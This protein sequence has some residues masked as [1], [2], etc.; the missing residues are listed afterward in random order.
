M[1]RSS[2]T[3]SSALFLTIVFI[4]AASSTALEITPFRTANRSPL[5][6][7]YGIPSETSSDLLEAGKYEFS[8]T[9]DIASINVKD[10]TA[11]EQMFLDGELY[12]WSLIGRYG[13]GQNLELGFEL[14]YVV[15]EGGFLDGFIVGWHD[16]FGLPQGGRNIFPRNRMKY[17]YTRDGVSRLDARP[18]TNGISD[19]SLLAGYQL[20]AHRDD[21]NHDTLALRAQLKLPTGDSSDM[22][23]S[24]STDLSLFITGSRNSRSEWGVLGSFASLGGMYGSDGNILKQQ[25]QNLAGFGSIGTGWAPAEWIAFKLQCH[26]TTPLYKD[27]NL[28]E[29]GTW[30]ALLTMG[31]TLK[32][33]DNYL[34]DIGVGE[35]ILVNS[36][37]DVTFNLALSKRF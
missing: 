15:Q 19:M 26:F 16:F 1:L 32:F 34:L 21:Q 22:L 13:L 4:F 10:H 36:A 14:P 28:R 31:G 5:L 29:L 33:P 2:F 30:T 6:Y 27:S 37:P 7:F 24:G 20:Y 12:R 8:I 18:A 9:Q 25:R 11:R 35:D 17:Q 23:G 3:Y